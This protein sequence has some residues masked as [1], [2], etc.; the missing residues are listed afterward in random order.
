MRKA[1][2]KAGIIVQKEDVGGSSSRTVRIDVA[3]GK[4]LL[5]TS[6]GPDR[7]MIVNSKKIGAGDGLQHTHRR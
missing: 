2:W 3:T 1:C 5:S 6:G 4:V 7:E